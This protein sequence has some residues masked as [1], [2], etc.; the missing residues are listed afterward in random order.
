MVTFSPPQD[1]RFDAKLF[2]EGAAGTGKTT[3]A[4]QY[5]LSLLDQ[6]IAPDRV[7]VMVP[8]AQRCR[9]HGQQQDSADD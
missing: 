4:I 6:G 2:L 1:V 9:P 5:L 3:Y 8:Q 7:L